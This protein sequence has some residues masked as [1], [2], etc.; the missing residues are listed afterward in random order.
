MPNDAPDYT[1]PTVTGGGGSIVQPQKP[2]YNRD[3]TTNAQGYVYVFDPTTVQGAK[4]CTLASDPRVLG[5]QN[6][7]A[8]PPGEIAN[9][10][11]HGEGV[12]NVI[13]SGSAGNALVTSTTQG[14]AMANGTITNQPGFVGVALQSWAGPGQIL[15]DID[16]QTLLWGGQVVEEGFI[17]GNSSSGGAGG[18]VAV[19][20][21]CGVNLNRLVVALYMCASAGGA[22]NAPTTPPKVNGVNMTLVAS[23]DFTGVGFSNAHFDLYYYL[24]PPTGLVGCTTAVGSGSSNWTSSTLFVAYSGALQAGTFG[25]IE[26]VALAASSAPAVQCS[27][28]VAGDG[29]FGAVIDCTSTGSITGHGAGQTP[30]G[31]ASHVESNAAVIFEA[32]HKTATVYNETMSWTLA[33]ADKVNAVS[34]PIHPA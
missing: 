4:A 20:L 7:V 5:V 23:G 3:V 33:A 9:L 30:D 10:L 21:Q 32:D 26:N 29:I 6:D 12:V 14:S 18:A 34:I 2:Y 24:A 22:S 17:S 27:D 16:V 28:A 25:T 15:A 11:Y 8:V 31:S 19:N 13:G 1:V